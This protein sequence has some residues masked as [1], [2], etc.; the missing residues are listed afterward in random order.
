M[1]FR[2]LC[3]GRLSVDAIDTALATWW[4]IENH[5]AKELMDCLVVPQAPAAGVQPPVSHEARI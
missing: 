4:S 5:T 2:R 1:K 3:S